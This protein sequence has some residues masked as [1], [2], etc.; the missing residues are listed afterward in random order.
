[1]WLCPRCVNKKADE[2]SGS[3]IRRAEHY[4][5]VWRGGKEVHSFTCVER[6]LLQVPLWT[7]LWPDIPG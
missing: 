3:A 5:R 1:V 6:S 4:S 2:G 7:S